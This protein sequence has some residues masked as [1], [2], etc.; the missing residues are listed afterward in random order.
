MS[1]VLRACEDLG[2]RVVAEGVETEAERDTLRGM[3]VALF[4]GWL[5]ARPA[6]GALAAWP[7]GEPRAGSV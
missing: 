5:F 4:Q 7:G 1:S 3:G 2:I 6:S